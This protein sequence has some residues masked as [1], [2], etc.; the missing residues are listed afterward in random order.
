MKPHFEQGTCQIYL[1]NSLD[2]LKELTAESVHCVVTSPPYWGLRDYG[3]ADWDGGDS[4]CDHSCGG[5][6]NQTKDAGTSRGDIYTSGVRPGID[7][8]TCLK[9]GATRVDDQIGL[10][11]TPEE[12]IAKLVELFREVRRVL[13]SDGTL[14]INIGDS[15]NAQPGQLKVTDKAGVKQASD[16]GSI[17]APSRSVENLKPKDLVGIPWMLAFALRADGRWLRQDIIW[18]KPNPM[19]ESVTDRCTKSHEYVFLLSKSAKYYYNADAIKEKATGQGGLAN[20]FE[21]ET[22]ECFVPGHANK[23]HRL[24]RKSSSPATHGNIP[25]R[26]DGGASCHKPGQEYRNKRSVWEIIP[27]SLKEA[28]FATYPTE[29][30]KPCILAGCPEGGTVLDPF[31]GSG[32]TGLVARDNGCKYIGIELNPEYIEISAKRL[33]QDV[34]QF[35]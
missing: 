14:W 4:E 20:S 5:Q 33:A 17:G 35:V 19:P 31:S 15:Y 2:V 23:Q 32:T 18:S 3:T 11:K 25:G 7:S 26:S 12:Y 8:S 34:L 24:N 22:K 28:H 30:V 29:L 13:R 21:R 16:V 6:V 1:G 10:E 9:C 27:E